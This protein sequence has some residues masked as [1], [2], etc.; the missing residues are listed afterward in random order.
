MKNYRKNYR[1]RIK[2]TVIMAFFTALFTASFTA[3]VSFLLIRSQLYQEQK[4]WKER[5]I[6]ERLL[7]MNDRQVVLFEEINSG[8]LEI[9]ILTKELKLLSARSNVAY[10]LMCTTD[11]IEEMNLLNSKMVD[12]HLKLYKLSSKFQMIPLYFTER[13]DSLISPL[14]KSLENNFNKN[15]EVGKKVDLHKIDSYF[16]EQ[17]FNTTQELTDTRERLL[18]AMFD[19]MSLVTKKT[20]DVQE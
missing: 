9:E 14:N 7:E 20:F 18:K 2:E 8:I 11:A 15:L 6:K 12:Y 17:D 19:D 4:Y 3:I 16:Q 10:S 5:L 1:R 13:V